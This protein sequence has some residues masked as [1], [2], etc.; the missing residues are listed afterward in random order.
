MHLCTKASIQ[1]LDSSQ[2]KKKNRTKKTEACPL[3]DKKQYK[4]SSTT[5]DLCSTQMLYIV[6]INL[7]YLSYEDGH[8]ISLQFDRHL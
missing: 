2:G 6:G 3:L 7:F 8:D 1:Q 4:W 5:E